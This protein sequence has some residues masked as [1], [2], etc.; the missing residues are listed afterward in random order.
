MTASAPGY[1]SREK[2]VE[3]FSAI[4]AGTTADVPRSKTMPPD[5]WRVVLNWDKTSRARDSW[6]YFGSHLRLQ[7]GE[8][9]ML[10]WTQ[11][12]LV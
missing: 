12:R 11:V 7:R 9:K 6:I 2:C 3:E 8:W 1:I 5:T 4:R 10:W